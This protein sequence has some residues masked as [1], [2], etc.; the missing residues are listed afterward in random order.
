LAPIPHANQPLSLLH[1]ET[2]VIRC[3]K[4]FTHSGDLPHAVGG[5]Q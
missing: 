2:E 4:S 5:S 1:D 3:A